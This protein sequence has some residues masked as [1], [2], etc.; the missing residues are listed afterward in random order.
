MLPLV[1]HQTADFWDRPEQ[2]NPSR[3]SA[4][5]PPPEC[6]FPSVLTHVGA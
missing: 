5:Y 6:I 1:S 4:T 2:F 3:W